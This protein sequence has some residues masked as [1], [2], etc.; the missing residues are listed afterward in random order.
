MVEVGAR[1]ED[2]GGAR[3]EDG[4]RVAIEALER[5]LECVCVAPTEQVRSEGGL[6]SVT[7]APD[8]PDQ[9]G[10]ARRAGEEG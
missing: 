7:S 2:T 5:T 4:D 1:Q 9:E 8:R 6:A 3:A 10:G